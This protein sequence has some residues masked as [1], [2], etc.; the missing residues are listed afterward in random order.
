MIPWLKRKG[1]EAGRQSDARLTEIGWLVDAEQAGFIYDAPRPAAGRRRKPEHP[2]AVGACPAVVDHEARLWEIPCPFDLHLR[3][4][5]NEQ[6]QATLVNAA[7]A[8]SP[9]GKPKLEKLVHLMP[10]A[11]WRDPRRPVLQVSAPWRFV[12][13]EQVWISQLP[14]FNHYA[15]APWP[16]LLIGG[17]FPLRDWPRLLMWAFEWWDCDKELVLKRGDPWFYVRFETPTPDRPIRLVEAEMTPAL[18]AFCQ[19]LD[20]V[21]NYVNQTSQLFDVARSRRPEILLSKKAG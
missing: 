5:R 6:G 19:G 9:V 20:G 7:G 14:P 10:Q 12:T 21:T 1:H 13:D 11:T 3:I 4:G 18:K 16:G 15:A 8:R 2:K 17:R